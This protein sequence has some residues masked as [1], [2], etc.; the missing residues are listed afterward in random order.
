MNNSQ[1]IFSPQII[2]VLKFLKVETFSTPLVLQL[3]LEHASV[4]ATYQLLKRMLALK[5]IRCAKINL[6]AGRPITLYGITS[7][8]LAYAWD[9]HE[10]PVERPTFQPSKV[11]VSTLQHKLDLQLIHIHTSRAQWDNWID[12]SQLGMR[13]EKRKVPD[14]IVVDKQNVIYAIEIEREIKSSKRYREII[15]SHLVSR[16]SGFWDKILYLCPTQDLAQRLDR[17][18]NSIDSINVSGRQIQLTDKH[19]Q[20]FD[21]FGYDR[22]IEKITSHPE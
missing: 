22:F 14:A 6:L 18:L 7:H 13:L 4:Q 17:K 2:N 9:L 1:A 11:S 3:L 21:F 8:G 12:G 16:K 19:F 20:F 10:D 5:L 15:V